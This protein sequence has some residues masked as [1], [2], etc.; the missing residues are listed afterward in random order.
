MPESAIIESIKERIEILSSA[1]SRRSNPKSM[2][3]LKVL[4]DD[5]LVRLQKQY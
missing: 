5:V 3:N 1:S 4:I 2:S